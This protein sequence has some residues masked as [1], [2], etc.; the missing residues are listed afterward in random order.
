M[1]SAF[2][3]LH[4]IDIF[5]ILNYIQMKI[6]SHNTHLCKQHGGN[7]RRLKMVLFAKEACIRIESCCLINNLI[8][9]QSIKIISFKFVDEDDCTCSW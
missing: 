8:I 2:T 7:N 3:H 9:K 5:D 1:S 4:A 6:D